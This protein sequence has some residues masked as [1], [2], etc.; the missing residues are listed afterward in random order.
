MPMKTA[1]AAIIAAMLAASPAF[2]QLGHDIDLGHGIRIIQEMVVDGQLNVQ[3]D[4]DRFGGSELQPD[5]R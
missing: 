5:I 4:R 3:S 1:T 2:A